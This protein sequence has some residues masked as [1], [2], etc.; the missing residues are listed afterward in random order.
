MKKM[1]F[2]IIILLVIGFIVA[3]NFPLIED[4]SDTKFLDNK[5]QVN[6]IIK[7]ESIIKGSIKLN[8]IIYLSQN[9]PHLKNDI[10]NSIRMISDIK[11]PYRLFKTE[12]N[13]TILVIKNRDSIYFKLI[14]YSKDNVDDPTFK[15]L[16]QN[17]F[18]K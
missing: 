15:D 6:A 10:N 3:I 7:D 13:D 8:D 5:T 12:N 14:D 16:F 1:I 11:P 4:F 17:I 2:G 9:T 18:K